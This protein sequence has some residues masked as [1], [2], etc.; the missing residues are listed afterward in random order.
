MSGKNP[1]V[2]L[3][4]L[5]LLLTFAIAPVAA[6]EE[7]PIYPHMMYF[8]NPSCRLC[9]KTNEVVGEAE[10]KYE[11]SM[12]YQRMNISDPE[13]GIANVDYMFQLLDAMEVPPAD[14]VTLVVFLGLLSN[15]DGQYEFEP[16]R[17]LVE[18]EDIIPKLDAEIAD[19]LSKEA[20]GG[21]PIAWVRQAGFFLPHSPCLAFAD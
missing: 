14:N 8:Y 13:E 6:A 3:L 17:V 5:A 15:V 12:S 4:P 10:K 19:F 11:K 16:K 1:V 18:G 20:K 21:K 7:A 2:K 9:T